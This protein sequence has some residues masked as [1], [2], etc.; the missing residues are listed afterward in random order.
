[1]EIAGEKYGYQEAFGKKCDYQEGDA[2][3]NNLQNKNVSAEKHEPRLGE[4]GNRGC[5]CRFVRGIFGA[6]AFSLDDS[7]EGLRNRKHN[8]G[9]S[10]KEKEGLLFSS[11]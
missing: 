5:A 6:R 2:D 3:G 7:K 4:S 1:M 9:A 11:K 10:N 8:R